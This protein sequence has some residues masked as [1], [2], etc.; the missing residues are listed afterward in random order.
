MT[1]AWSASVIVLNILM[2][3]INAWRLTRWLCLSE[4]NLG[5]KVGVLLDEGSPLIGDFIFGEDCFDRALRLASS[6]VD[7]FIGVDVKLYDLV[8]LIRS[9]DRM[10]AVDGA[11]VDAGRIFRPDTWFCNDKG[12]R[13]LVLLLLCSSASVGRD[14]RFFTSF[15]HALRAHPRHTINE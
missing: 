2:H 9:L 8:K 11:H 1:L 3:R 7:A 15:Y 10:D 12:H 13:G 5:E 14:N 4:W 6:A